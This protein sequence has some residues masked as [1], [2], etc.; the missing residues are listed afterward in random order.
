MAD[1]E[2]LFD[3]IDPLR[4]P[5]TMAPLYAVLPEALHPT[6]V[7]MAE[8]MYLHLVEDAEAVKLLGLPRLADITVGQLDRVALHCGGS[9]FYMP[10]GIAQ[11][12]GERD[13]EIVRRY[14]GRNKR[15]LAREYKLCEVRIDQILAAYRRVEFE[16]RQGKLGFDG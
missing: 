2:S 10:K 6:L 12:L 3:P 9:G 4:D 1:S 16:R 7:E 8:Q 15:Q 5:Q 14:N 11:R 13:M